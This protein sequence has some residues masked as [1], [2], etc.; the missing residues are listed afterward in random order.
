MNLRKIKRNQH[1]I[2]QC[3]LKRFTIEGQKSL[4][5]TIDKKTGQYLKTTSSIKK[6]CSEDYYYYQLDDEGNVDHIGIEDRLSETE[7]SVN[8]LLQT[9]CDTTFGNRPDLSEENQG[10][11][12][13]FLALLITRGPSFRDPI[14]NLH[15]ELLT[16]LMLQMDKDNLFPEAPDILQK[17]IE[18][19]GIENVIHAHIHP[20][21]S[22]QAMIEGARL[23]ALSMLKKKWIF[24]RAKDNLY[25]TSNNPIHFS[26]SSR[27]RNLSGGPGHPQSIL[28]IALS[29]NV[30]LVIKPE[31][32]EKCRFSDQHNLKM[33]STSKSIVNQIN[34][35]VICSADKF[36]FSSEKDDGIRSMV[37]KFKDTKQ[38]VFIDTPNKQS[39]SVI[40]NPYSKSLKG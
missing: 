8:P 2:P 6:I 35:A 36:V 39:Y 20:F 18:E 22:L 25:V 1:Y 30:A 27:Y 23:I 4:L 7:R 37:E 28:T 31:P 13:F 29:K 19:K 34:K 14:N 16:K 38:K 11:L 33:C 24:Y 12:A 3:Y 32:L 40:K 5:W 9:I 15:G 10:E 26:F 21:V 17:M